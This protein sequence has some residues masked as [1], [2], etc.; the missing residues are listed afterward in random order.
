MGMEAAMMVMAAS[1]AARMTSWAVDSVKVALEMEGSWVILIIEVM[2]ALRNEH[3][4][5]PGREF[6]WGQKGDIVAGVR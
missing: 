5:P 3:G 4:E 1:A 6:L 2:P